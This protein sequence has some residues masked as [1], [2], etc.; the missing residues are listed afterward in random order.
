VDISRIFIIDPESNIHKYNTDEITTY[1]EM[2][3]NIHLYFPP[4]DEGEYQL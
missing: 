3:K 1:V 4:V 2:N